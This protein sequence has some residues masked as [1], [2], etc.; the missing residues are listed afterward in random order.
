MLP[1]LQQNYIL[2]TLENYQKALNL[3]KLTWLIAAVQWCFHLHGSPLDL[4][5][6]KPEKFELCRNFL[7]C[8]VLVPRTP[9]EVK[10]YRNLGTR[11]F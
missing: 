3:L 4:H 11:R 10:R 6:N 5:N 2:K 8:C 9:M 1:Y 7:P